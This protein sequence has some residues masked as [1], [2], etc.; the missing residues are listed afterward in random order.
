MACAGQLE[1]ES[2]MKAEK[3]VDVW[4][5]SAYGWRSRPPQGNP[6]LAL[7]VLLRRDGFRMITDPSLGM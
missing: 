3:G 2:R 6:C 5:S 7:A 1:E 4:S